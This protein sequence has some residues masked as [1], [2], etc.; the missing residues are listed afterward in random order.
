MMQFSGAIAACTVPQFRYKRDLLQTPGHHCWHSI[1]A[2]AS[3]LRSSVALAVAAADTAAV[4]RHL[5][6]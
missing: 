1:E 5:L 6:Q 2:D 3:T 4:F